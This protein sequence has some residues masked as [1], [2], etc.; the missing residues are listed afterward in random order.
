MVS[1]GGGDFNSSYY[2]EKMTPYIEKLDNA[3]DQSDY[4]ILRGALDANLPLLG[5]CRGL[6]W[7]NVLYGGTLYQDIPAQL[8]TKVT[9][10]DPKRLVNTYHDVTIKKG[11]K[12]AEMIGSGVQKL[13]SWHHQG[14]KKV[15][16][17]LSVSATTNDGLVEGIE[18]T[19]KKF[20]VGVQFHP[21]KMYKDRHIKYL[22]LFKRLVD[23]SK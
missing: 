20:V 15:G 3:R 23:E 5:I 18:A 1:I 10:R 4:W 8:G 22:N 19:D 13:D 21:E 11:T 14:I 7:I 16:Q 12:L 6:Q 2:G 17:N 9:H